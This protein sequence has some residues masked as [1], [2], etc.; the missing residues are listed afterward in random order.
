MKER[1]RTKKNNHYSC[2][3]VFVFAGEKL[4]IGLMIVFCFVVF[5]FGICGLSM[6]SGVVEGWRACRGVS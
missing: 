5:F 6:I 4:K 1:K 3:F 2:V